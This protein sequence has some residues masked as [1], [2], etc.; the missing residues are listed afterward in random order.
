METF[1]QTGY[2]DF[3]FFESRFPSGIETFGKSFF[4][5]SR[6]GL[7]GLVDNVCGFFFRFADEFLCLIASFLRI[8]LRHVHLSL[9]FFKSG[10]LC[11][12]D[13]F[14][15]FAVSVGY[16]LLFFNFPLTFKFFRFVF[17]IFKCR[18]L[19]NR[20][21]FYHLGSSFRFKGFL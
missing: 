7:F 6:F 13:N 1:Y 15:G 18:P 11:V 10:F 20:N 3:S 17:E 8:N 2:F 21:G 16:E 9:C 19:G 5:R 12:F 4:L 14:I